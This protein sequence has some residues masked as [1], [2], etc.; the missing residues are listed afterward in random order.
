MFE[1]CKLPGDGTSEALP[2]SL[3]WLTYY[4]TDELD[5]VLSR[6]WR[7]AICSVTW[8]R[9]EPQFLGPLRARYRVMVLGCYYLQSI[10]CC[11]TLL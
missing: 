10:K 9:L 7:Q 2:L 8:S 4:E 1:V 11:K 3:T 6:F 5:E